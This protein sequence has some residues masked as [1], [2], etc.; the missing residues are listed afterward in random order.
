MTSAEA[1]ALAEN[2]AYAIG[3]LAPPGAGD[4]LLAAAD[5]GSF[6]EIV[7]AAAT[8]LGLMGPACPAKAQ[9]KLRDLA[10]SEDQQIQP[11]AVR[12]AAQ[13]GK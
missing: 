4:A 2:A 6:P 1:L 12:A 8:G 3:R 5:D 10:N 7:A 13:C 11:A 9:A